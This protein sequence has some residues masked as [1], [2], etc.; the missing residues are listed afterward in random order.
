MIVVY[1]LIFLIGIL[2]IVAYFMKRNHYVQREII[3]NAP[4]QK[5]FDFLRFLKN[6][7]QFNKWAKAGG[8]RQEKFTGEDGTVGFIYA[9]SGDKSAGEGEKEIM[10]IVNGERIE[11]EIRF[12]KPMKI[13]AFVIME[14][15][16]VSENQ[17]KVNMI[18]G[19]NLNFPFNIMIP[20]AEK[21][22]G[23]DMDASL[24][25]LKKILE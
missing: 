13:S 16:A 10:K 12:I 15:H 25:S 4:R 20:I 21:N 24:V 6:Q 19:G 18:N 23:K 14:T 11:T 1:V 2:L 5:V 22:F 17:T 8:N 3:I 9:W 7:E